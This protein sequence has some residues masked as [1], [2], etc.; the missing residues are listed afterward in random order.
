MWW[1]YESHINLPLWVLWQQSALWEIGKVR[2]KSISPLLNK[3]TNLYGRI[4][5]WINSHVSQ[6]PPLSAA[7]AKPLK[8]SKFSDVE[9]TISPDNRVSVNTLISYSIIPWLSNSPPGRSTVSTL[10]DCK[11]QINLCPLITHFCQMSSAPFSLPSSMICFIN[12][13][14]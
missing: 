11:W 1:C 3:W 14:V 5:Q 7:P 4:E 9:T 13:A 12:T 8:S 10:S 2:L 6:P